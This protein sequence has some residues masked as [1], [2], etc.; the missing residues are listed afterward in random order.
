MNRS[1]TNIDKITM[2]IYEI[3]KSLSNFALTE[4]EKITLYKH[5]SSNKRS[6]SKHKIFTNSLSKQM[7]VKTKIESKSR[8]LETAI[9]IALI[10]F[11]V[12]FIYLVILYWKK[13]RHA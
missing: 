10:L 3:P 5:L 6:P 12:S 9:W 7:F 11:L 8:Y 1:S 2:K 4:K 13:L